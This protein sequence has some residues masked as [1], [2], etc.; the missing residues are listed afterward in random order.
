MNKTRSLTDAQGT[1]YTIDGDTREILHSID[2]EGNI[3]NAQGEPTNE[4]IHW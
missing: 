1:R 2:R 3:Y 4:N